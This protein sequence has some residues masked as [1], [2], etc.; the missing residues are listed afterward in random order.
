MDEFQP[1]SVCTE[2]AIVGQ[3]KLVVKSK[4]FLPQ[5]QTN[6]TF[7][8]DVQFWRFMFDKDAFFMY[9]VEWKWQQHKKRKQFFS[10]LIPIIIIIFIISGIFLLLQCN[11]AVEVVVIFVVVVVAIVVI[12]TLV[13]LKEEKMFPFWA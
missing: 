3:F 9:L 12:G 2:T 8:C 1:L 5:Q 7:V 6:P 10:L 11:A 4:K 13:G